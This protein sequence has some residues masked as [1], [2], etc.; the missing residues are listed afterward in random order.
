MDSFWDGTDY[1]CW[2]PK[3]TPWSEFPTVTIT[4]A[5]SENSTFELMLSPQQYLRAVHDEFRDEV[6]DDCY[7]FAIAPSITGTVLGAVV[8]EGYYVVFDRANK[9]I[10]FAETTCHNINSQVLKSK[11]RGPHNSQGK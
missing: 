2:A 5:E 8:M 11:V 9:R 6:P 4:L 1:L 10:G 3:T 7:K